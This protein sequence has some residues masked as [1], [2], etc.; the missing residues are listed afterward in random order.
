LKFLERLHN[1]PFLNGLREVGRNSVLA[2][3]GR[4]SQ[5]W[6]FRRTDNSPLKKPSFKIAAIVI[7][8]CLVVTTFPGLGV[9]LCRHMESDRFQDHLVL[10]TRDALHG[11]VV[12]PALAAS[13]AVAGAPVSLCQNQHSCI[14]FS[15]NFPGIVSSFPGVLVQK[16]AMALLPLMLLPSLLFLFANHKNQRAHPLSRGHRMP[17]LAITAL[18]SVV[19]LR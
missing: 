1:S 3:R 4:K 14:H 7:L 5:G 10:G 6:F 2:N 12:K 15:L 19:L 18:R 8:L 11:S 17:S 9:T 13:S 16:L